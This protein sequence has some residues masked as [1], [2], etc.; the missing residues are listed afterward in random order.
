[1]IEAVDI[2]EGLTARN[3]F[4]FLDKHGERLSREQIYLKFCI[5]TGIGVTPKPFKKKDWLQLVK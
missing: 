2:V 3:I 5:T 4:I 1:M